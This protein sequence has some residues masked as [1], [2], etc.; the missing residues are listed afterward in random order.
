MATLY[1]DRRDVQLDW[2]DG[3]LRVCEAGGTPRGYPIGGLERVV[4]HGNATA[5]TRLLTRLAEQGVATL[6]LNGRGG[7]RHAQIGSFRHGDGLR[8]LGQYQLCSHSG[9]SLRWSR[10]LVRTRGRQ[11]LRLY[12]E[13]LARRPDQR[14]AL[15][16]VNGQLQTGLAAARRASS[17]SM[18]RGIEGSMAAAHFAVYQTLFPSTAGFRGRNR[19][20][21]RDPV[22]AALSLGYT[23]THSDAV[24][25]CLVA[26]LDPMLGTLH[27]PS[28]GRESLA[29]DFNEL[30]R[31][32]V[33][34]LVWR[35][36][37][38]RAL[39]REHFEIRASGVNLN[40][41]ARE[42]FWSAYEAR[43]PRH[44]RQLRSATAAF[45]RHCRKLAAGNS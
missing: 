41:T 37:A 33:E 42:I 29:C 6:L 38:E 27:A 36:F 16:R 35:L 14:R 4:I 26:G 10:L 1:I 45:A 30:A 2:Q 43:A 20:P 17:L 31:S 24:R 3:Q 8:R 19:R 18:L 7:R 40:K 9:H 44:R 22:N 23:L 12:R 21:P 5:S 28:H 11:L 32:H 15:H 34:H 13:A 25:A 39:R